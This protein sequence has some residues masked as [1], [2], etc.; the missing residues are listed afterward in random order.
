[1]IVPPLIGND[2]T[3]VAKPRSR[4][5]FNDLIFDGAILAGLNRYLKLRRLTGAATDGAIHFRA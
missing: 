3:W 5:K 1:M 2:M 4:Q